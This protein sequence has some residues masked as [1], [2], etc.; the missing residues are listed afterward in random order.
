MEVGEFSRLVEVSSNICH[1]FI[2]TNKNVY[3]KKININSYV[4]TTNVMLR[5]E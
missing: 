2:F 1:K 5:C 4:L 3:L